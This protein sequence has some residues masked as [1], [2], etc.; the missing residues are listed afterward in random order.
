MVGFDTIIWANNGDQSCERREGELKE[1]G[2]EPRAIGPIRRVRGAA[3]QTVPE[4]Y[5]CKGEKNMIT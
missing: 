4:R 3:K 2:N 5:S 1:M